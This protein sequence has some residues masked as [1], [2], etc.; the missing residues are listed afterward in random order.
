MKDHN[1]LS[2]FVLTDEAL[3]EILAQ[4][5]LGTSQPV[6]MGY[7]V[8]VSLMSFTAP[9]GS[10][11]PGRRR[12]GGSMRAEPRGHGDPKG[13]ASHSSPREGWHHWCPG[14]YPTLLEMT[15]AHPRRGRSHRAGFAFFKRCWVPSRLSSAKLRKK[16]RGQNRSPKKGRCRRPADADWPGGWQN[17]SDKSG[18]SWLLCNKK[19]EHISHSVMS[20]SLQP[21]EL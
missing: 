13:P 17:N 14:F 1:L 6:E 18:S 7:V 5:C 20:D 19:Q 4:P 15:S 21:H 10:G 16:W 11:S 12:A 8:A 3:E 9:L 2:I